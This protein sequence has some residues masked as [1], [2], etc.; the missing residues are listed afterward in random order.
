[1]SEG[2]TPESITRA[3]RPPKILLVVGTILI[4]YVLIGAVLWA[5]N[6]A[7]SPGVAAKATSLPSSVRSQSPLTLTL[8]HTN[9]TWGYTRPCG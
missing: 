5:V 4:A 2:Q 9:D 8:L 1:M 7:S 6:S 3:H